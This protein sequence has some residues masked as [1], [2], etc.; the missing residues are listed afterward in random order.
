MISSCN[1]NR[2]RPLNTVQSINRWC[3]RGEG[4]GRG[5]RDIRGDSAE[6]FYK[7]FPREAIVGSS[8][9]TRVVHFLTPKKSQHKKFTLEKKILPPL[10]S[11]FESRSFGDESGAQP[12]SYPGSPIWCLFQPSVTAVACKRP[13]SF[14]RKCR[15]LQV[16]PKRGYTLD[17][18]KSEST[19]HA[20]V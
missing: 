16:A 14:C 2:C 15:L 17:P 8:G 20:V 9:I 5:R 1:C 3:H 18:V 12:A 7:S 13:R 10:L 19:N 6:T 4:G 11:G